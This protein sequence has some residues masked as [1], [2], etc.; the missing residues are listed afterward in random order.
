M[1]RLRKQE[2]RWR[3]TRWVL[4]IGGLALIGLWAWMLYYVFETAAESQDR[5]LELLIQAMAYPKVLF[6]MIIG[7]LMIGLALRDWFGS[8]TRTLLL[9]LLQEHQAEL[10]S[11]P[12]CSPTPSVSGSEVTK[13]PQSV[14]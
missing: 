4:L 5:K 10:G 9:R 7:A 6:G 2:R 13:G 1:E 11:G 3:F 8:P 12:S 14:T